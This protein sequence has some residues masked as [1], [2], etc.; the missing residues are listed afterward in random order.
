MKW[1]RGKYNG[2]RIVGF[3]VRAEF[4]VLPH[5]WTWHLPGRYGRCLGF[6]PLKIWFSIAYENS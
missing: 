6:G 5:W 4:Q 3:Q 2:D 1:P